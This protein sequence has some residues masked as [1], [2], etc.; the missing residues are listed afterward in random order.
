MKDEIKAVL[1]ENIRD[2]NIEILDKYSNDYEILKNK[3]FLNLDGFS[4]EG[5][6]NDKSLGD[7]II[8]YI[9]DEYHINNFN[10]SNK[11]VLDIGA[12]MGTFSIK[13]L[14]LG[15]NLY[16]FEPNRRIFKLLKRNINKNQ[17]NEKSVLS[18]RGFWIGN[19]WKI[20]FFKKYGSGAASI[21]DNNLSFKNKLLNRSMAIFKLENL[22]KYIEDSSIKFELI[23][24]D[25][26][27]AEY[28]IIE[29]FK[30]IDTN[31]LPNHLVLE[32][33]NGI[34]N[35]ERNLKLFR[36]ETKIISRE[37]LQ[38]LILAKKVNI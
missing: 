25:I 10:L 18:N 22:N 27:G 28:K 36:Y 23:K 17:F 29:N 2:F 31:L 14:S 34:Q 19:K 7:N 5:Y 13:C 20:V 15:A 9:N 6:I 8:E 24:L 16:S 33:H 21:V 4:L 37:N 30:N 26:E 35:L 32:Y 3:V 1:K 12:N 11:N 38:G